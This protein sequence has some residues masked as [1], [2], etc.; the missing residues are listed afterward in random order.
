MGFFLNSADGDP[1]NL[2]PLTDDTRRKLLEDVLDSDE[3]STRTAICTLVRYREKALLYEV[4]KSN[5]A[6]AAAL[7][8]DAIWEIWHS[9]HGEDAQ[10]QIERGMRYLAAGKH[11]DALQVFQCMM[12]AFHEWPEPMYKAA[13]VLYFCG[14]LEAC[15]K[16]NSK[17]VKLDPLHFGAWH[18]MAM[19]AL[20]LGRRDEAQQAIEKALEIQPHSPCREDM[21]SFLDSISA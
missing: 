20:Q 13:S 6:S 7:A 21:L 2:E 14:R 3:E 18:G 8:E 15:Y 12:H 11:C 5:S 17:V 10:K 4:L 19:S 1:S 9:E 16:L